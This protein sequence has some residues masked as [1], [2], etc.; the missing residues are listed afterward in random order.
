MIV[1]K[2]KLDFD[3][4]V[5]FLKISWIKCSFS[6]STGDDLYEKNKWILQYKGLS[7][8]LQKWV[9]KTKQLVAEWGR[10]ETEETW[11]EKLQLEKGL[12]N[13]G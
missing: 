2:K 11:M 7:S 9:K 8:M 13:K 3:L 5:V 10:K 1:G 4:T 12:D 6:I